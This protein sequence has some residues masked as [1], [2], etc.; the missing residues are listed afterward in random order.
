MLDNDEVYLDG[1]NEF[2]GQSALTHFDTNNEQNH[3]KLIMCSLKKVNYVLSRLTLTYLLIVSKQ[4][5]SFDL[6]P[7]ILN[8]NSHKKKEKEIHLLR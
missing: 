3:F 2:F 4:V 6:N 7:F 1:L 5:D 8:T